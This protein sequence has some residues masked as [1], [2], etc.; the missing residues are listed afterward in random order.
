[1]G[2][3]AFSKL[4]DESF[5]FFRKN[6]ALLFS[7]GLIFSYLPR[8]I[9]E[10]TF[11]TFTL[12]ISSTIILS[13][14]STLLVVSLIFFVS[15]KKKKISLGEVLN[16]SSRFYVRAILLFV[17]LLLLF[18]IIPVAIVSLLPSASFLSL[19]ILFL[20]FIFGIMFSIYWIFV[21]YVLVVKDC[22]VIDAMKGSKKIVEKR[23]LKVF[24][25]FVLIAI[26][27][28]IINI[29]FNGA[30]IEEP[31]GSGEKVLFKG[32]FEI[33]LSLIPNF[34]FILDS[35]ISSVLLNFIPTL[36]SLFGAIFMMKY[37]L[38]LNVKK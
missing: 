29:S 6:F 10:V 4:W 32:I 19:M 37:Y 23:W 2:D 33:I 22:P 18:F 14:L 17:L 27:M 11:L 21:F 24:F 7:L 26:I 31:D 30:A 13:F 28:A 1:M 35:F 38:S 25:R 15:S 16:K 5:D 3:I 20:W 34:P 8:V 12:P 9:S 36:T